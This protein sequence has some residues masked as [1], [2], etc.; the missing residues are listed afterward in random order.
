MRV[1]RDKRPRAG[2]V[3]SLC[4]VEAGQDSGKSGVSATPA[5]HAVNVDKRESMASY[6]LFYMHGR[7]PI[8]PGARPM[9]RAPTISRVP[10]R[11]AHGPP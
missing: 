5:R 11:S 4:T 9:R 8:D 7:R 2:E 3:P 6:W 1:N 10:A